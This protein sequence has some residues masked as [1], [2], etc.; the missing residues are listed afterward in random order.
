MSFTVRSGKVVKG[1]DPILSFVEM[2]N[3]DGE[4]FYDLLRTWEM[5]DGE[6]A[7]CTDGVTRVL[8]RVRRPRLKSLFA[9]I[10]PP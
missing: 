1:R 3:E 8:A 5:P 6:Y 2:L 9:G 7:F 4:I 10:E